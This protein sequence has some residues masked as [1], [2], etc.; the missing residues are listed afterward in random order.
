MITFKKK[1]ANRSEA[2]IQPLRDCRLR[3]VYF[4][5]FL[6]TF[7]I[8]HLPFSIAEVRYVSPTGNNIPPYLTWE[9]AANVIQ[10]AINVCEPGDTVYV[11]NGIYKENLVINTEISLIGLSMDSTVVDGTGLGDFTI[12]FNVNGSIEN[13]NIY[14]RGKSFLTSRAIRAIGLNTNIEVNNC[15][16]SEAGAGVSLS[17]DL[18]ANNLLMKNLTRGINLFGNLINLVSNCVI[19]L[20]EQN[21]RGISIGFAPNADNHITNNIILHTG[22]NNQNA[23]GISVDKPRKVF[24]YNNVISRFGGILIQINIDSAVIRNNVIMNRGGISSINDD[25]IIENIILKNNNIGIDGWPVQ[26]DYNLFWE[27]NID[28]TYNNYGDSDRVADPMFVKDTIPTPDGNYNFQLQA[29]SPAI[30]AGNPDILDVDGSRSDIGLYIGGTYKYQDLAPKAPRN[31]TAVVDTNGILLKW[32]RNSEADTAHYNVYQDTVTNF[33]I[34][35]IRLV[36]SQTDTFFIQKPPFESSQY[37]YKITCVDNQGNESL[38]SEEIVIKVTSMTTN[39]YPMT[40]NDYRLYQNY[41]NPFNP[42][43]TIAYK[44]KERGYIKL[45]VYDITGSLVSV[46]VNKEQEAGYYEIEFDTRYQ[47]P[48]TGYRNLASGIYLYRIEVVGEGKI[49]VYSDMK[50]M[51][52]IK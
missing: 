51:I 8:F 33:N 28:Y 21:S 46:L 19:I 13:F 36:S 12:T 20:D 52:L 4:L 27:N 9:D 31:L 45:M 15:Q 42:S 41:P 37:V 7:Y 38:P 26:S 39:D 1:N 10:D 11:A 29:F 5:L 24:I 23:I 47:M 34:D 43:T 22:T 40:I 2:K 32:N 3:T 16:I 44:L 50:K 48:D 25:A 35:S 49:P 30:D 18:A 6:L 14:S 17:G